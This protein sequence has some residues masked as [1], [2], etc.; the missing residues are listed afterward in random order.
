MAPVCKVR[1]QQQQLLLLSL[2]VLHARR[3][4]KLKKK[5][6]KRFWVQTPN[7]QRSLQGGY[8][9]VIDL[10]RLENSHLHLYQNFIR[11]PPECFNK[12]LEYIREHITKDNTHL[13]ESISANQRLA[14]ILL[15]LATG[16]SMRVIAMFFRMG[17]STVREIIYS[18]CTAIWHTM[19]RRYLKTPT[20]QEWTGIAKE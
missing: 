10:Y 18:T 16:D 11:M 1:I 7:L 9:S 20:E 4:R 13:R 14:V 19:R 17:I 8:N 2:G 3:K 15:Y 5:Y 6:A 12:L